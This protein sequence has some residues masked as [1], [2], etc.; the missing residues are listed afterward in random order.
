MSLRQQVKSLSSILN[1]P[2]ERHVNHIG[3]NK[4]SNFSTGE[5]G[6]E[7]LLGY[8]ATILPETY[9]N[10]SPPGDPPRGEFGSAEQIQ[11][12]RITSLHPLS[13]NRGSKEGLA[14]RNP[15]EAGGPCPMRVPHE[16]GS[17]AER[18]IPVDRQS[19]MRKRRR[20]GHSWS[21]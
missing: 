6:L 8:V 9:P 10:S 14:S 1:Q 19:P 18:T 2:K 21:L 5:S 3:A 12:R 15:L 20:Q 11:F 4:N 7:I 16:R 13:H 17:R